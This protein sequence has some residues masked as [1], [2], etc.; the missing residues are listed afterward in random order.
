[1]LSL[2]TLILRP[3]KGQISSQEFPSILILITRSFFSQKKVLHIVPFSIKHPVFHLIDHPLNTLL[4]IVSVALR[5][6]FY[7]LTKS[8]IVYYLIK[9]EKKKRHIPLHFC[10]KPLQMSLGTSQSTHHCHQFYLEASR[11]NQVSWERFS[12]RI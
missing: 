7:L 11:E 5:D 10:L 4:M 2:V 1:M 12:S 8:F 6:L 9:Q 3:K